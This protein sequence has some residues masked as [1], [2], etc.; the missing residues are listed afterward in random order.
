MSVTLAFL[1]PLAMV[2]PPLLATAAP[3]VADQSM[4]FANTRVTADTCDL[5]G[6]GVDYIGIADRGHQA[7]ERM[8]EQGA[9][10][11]EAMDR[12]RADVSSVRNRFNSRYYS[13]IYL[14]RFNVLAADNVT[15]S[16]PQERFQKT[17]TKRC[18][19]LAEREETAALFAK[20][21]SRL[22]GAELRRR[23]RDLVVLA[24]HGE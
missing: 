10:Y 15:S 18:D 22:S 5:L 4:R 3:G 6:Y 12:I 14:E 7:R 17:F 23:V 13:A 19:D 1:A 2:S 8:M 21:E 16:G 11:D 9:T 20:P 24:R